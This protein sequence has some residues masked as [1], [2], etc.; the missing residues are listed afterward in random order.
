MVEGSGAQSLALVVPRDPIQPHIAG[1]QDTLCPTG[2]KPIFHPTQPGSGM[3]KSR[4][5]KEGAGEP[6]SPQSSPQSESP[7]P[8]PSAPLFVSPIARPL[9]TEKL[10]PR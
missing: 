7:K 5:T 4:K 9:A 6:S 1:S 3:G 8:V 10:T 2:K